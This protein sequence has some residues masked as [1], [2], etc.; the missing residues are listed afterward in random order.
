MYHKRKNNKDLKY[1]LSNLREQDEHELRLIHGQDWFKQSWNIWKNLKGCR[2]AYKDNGTPVA[3]F[4]VLPQKNV[5]IVG[6]LST[7]DIEKEQRSFLMQGK[8]WIES[9]ENEFEVLKNYVYSSNIKAIKW[10][11]WLGF[12]V[13]ENRGIGDKFLLFSKDGMQCA[14]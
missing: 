8:K 9:F 6:F 13:E 5:G 1:I 10:L 12:D 7:T 14:K 11:K 2:I 4:G 3:I